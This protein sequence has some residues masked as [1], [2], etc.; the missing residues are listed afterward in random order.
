MKIIY[1]NQWENITQ[2]HRSTWNKAYPAVNIDQELAKMK[3]W[4]D[5]NPNSKK[6]NWQRFIINWLSKAQDA[7]PKVGTVENGLA[8]I[9]KAKAMFTTT[10]Q[11]LEN[12]MK[13][14]NSSDDEIKA[15]LQ[16]QFLQPHDLI[17][18]LKRDLRL[19]DSIKSKS[20]L[21]YEKWAKQ[22]RLGCEI[23]GKEKMKELWKM[24]DNIVDND[25]CTDKTKE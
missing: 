23:W 7:A 6:S 13:V 3:A 15:Y 14:T 24:F 1:T 25:N 22:W 17:E 18:K 19:S 12:N 16:K 10:I 2:E 9:E 8:Q 21:A 4:I 5:A 20:G 11:T